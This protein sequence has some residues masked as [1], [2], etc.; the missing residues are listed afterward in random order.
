AVAALVGAEAW[1]LHGFYAGKPEYDAALALVAAL[2]VLLAK[3]SIR[4]K[5]AGRRHACA[6]SGA[7]P[8]VLTDPPV[9][10]NHSS[11]AGP[12]LG[13]FDSKASY[14]S[15]LRIQRHVGERRERVSGLQVGEGKEGSVRFRTRS[16]L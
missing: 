1:F 6:R 3:D 14:R 2:G 7:F 12:L 4:A 9:R 8:A 15:A 5:L 16:R 10:A 11:A 13:R